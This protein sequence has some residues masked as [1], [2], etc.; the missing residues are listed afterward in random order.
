MRHGN[1]V[2]HLGRK[3]GHRASMLK[4]LSNSLVSAKRINTTLAKAKVLRTHLEPLITKAVKENTT[5]SRRTVFSYLQDKE[6]VKE[7]FGVI[8]D[9]VGNR[10]GGYL[11][12]IKTGTRIGDGAPTALIEFV[13]FNE[14]YSVTTKSDVKKKRT[15]RG[16]SAVKKSAEVAAPVENTAANVAD[17]VTE[18][19]DD[20]ADAVE[21]T[22]QE[23]VDNTTETESNDDSTGDENKD[24]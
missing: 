9:K 16:S 1:K 4:N 12:I 19:V 18:V 11:R 14:T 22:S 3:T 10:P 15:R 13:D 5:H 23:I 6:S 24:A 20:A 8:A 21:T 7:L 2:N 17:D